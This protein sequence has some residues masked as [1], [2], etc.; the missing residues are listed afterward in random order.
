MIV[1]II[2][3]NNNNNNKAANNNNN[4]NIKAAN[5]NH[6]IMIKLAMTNNYAS[7]TQTCI[8]FYIMETSLLRS[9]GVPVGAKTRALSCGKKNQL[10]CNIMINSDIKRSWSR[11]SWFGLLSYMS[12]SPVHFKLYF[13]RLFIL[14]Y[15]ECFISLDMTGPQLFSFV[16]HYC[17]RAYIY[18]SVKM[19]LIQPT[20]ILFS[21]NEI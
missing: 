17:I 21:Q 6:N 15:L 14:F 16:T 10:S 4:N 7:A 1:T 18:V 20:W 5:S 9:Y 19:K 11:L 2:C 12:P 3:N 8:A 13:I